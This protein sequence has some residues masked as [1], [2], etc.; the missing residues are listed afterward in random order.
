MAGLPVALVLMFSGGAAL[1]LLAAI[2]ALIPKV[3]VISDEGLRFGRRGRLGSLR[4][5]RDTRNFRL[6]TWSGRFVSQRLIVWNDSDAVRQA[7]RREL[8][9]F[10]ARA[11]DHRISALWAGYTDE[12]VLT[13]IVAAREAYRK[14]SHEPAVVLPVIL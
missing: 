1:F 6:W 7:H 8:L 14:R 9:K 11:Y 5:W 12:E 10:A 13:L 3:L 2:A 4:P